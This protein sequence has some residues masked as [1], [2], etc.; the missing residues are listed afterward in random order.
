MF[1]KLMLPID[2]AHAAKLEKALQAAVDIARLYD[3]PITLVGVTAEVPTSVAH[4]PTEYA[5]KLKQFGADFA[6]KHSVAV[7]TK[8]YAAHDPSIDLDKAI[9]AA[10][11][12]TGCDLVV[13]ATH[14]PGVPEHFFASH[15]GAIA[16]H[17]PV[18]VFVVR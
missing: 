5:A 15:G 1:K 10:V 7:E 2:L 18:S 9:L 13:M 6:D 14:V 3:C 12:E 4:N 8:A 11:R 16:S 17:A